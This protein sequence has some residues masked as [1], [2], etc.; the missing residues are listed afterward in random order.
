L[1]GYRIDDADMKVQVIQIP[2]DSG[3]RSVRMGSGPEHFVSKGLAE[4]L[5]AEGYEVW[6]ETIESNAEFQAEIK[7]QFELYRLLAGRVAEARRNDK[8]PLVLSGNCSG[9]WARLSGRKQN[10]LA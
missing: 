7:T 10:G 5:R 3:N 9:L 4:V 2:Y 6:V 8:F 1:G